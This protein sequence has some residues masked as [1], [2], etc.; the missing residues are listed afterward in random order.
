MSEEKLNEIL[1]QLGGI[2][3]ETKEISSIKE[4]V[5]GMKHQMISINEKMSQLTTEVGELKEDVEKCKTESEHIHY[6]NAK[7]KTRLNDL[8]QYSRINNVIIKGIPYMANENLRTTVAKIATHLKININNNDIQVVHRLPSKHADKTQ[9]IIV[10]LNNRD[11]KYE[12]IK[13]TKSA[14]L[15]A[16]D[17]GFTTEMPIYITEHLT[18][19]N[20]DLMSF[21]IDLKKKGA[22]MFAWSKDGKILVKEREDTRTIRIQELSQLENFQK[23][24]D[25]A[26]T[27]EGGKDGITTRSGQKPATSKNKPKSK[28]VVKNK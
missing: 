18:R 2:K 4:T 6:E 1:K 26:S 9:S 7:L 15:N 21:A 5:E 17:L 20:A 27:C 23:Q 16:S 10:K 25:E 28:N 3:N 8:E 14:K 11:L 13:R 22:I 19:E 24:N 12:L